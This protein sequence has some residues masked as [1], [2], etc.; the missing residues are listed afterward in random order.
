MLVS[1]VYDFI[2]LFGLQD[3]K[4]GSEKSEGGLEASVRSFSVNISWIQFGFKFV[5]FLVLWKVSFNYLLDVK[6]V[7]EAPKIAK[8]MKI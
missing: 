2:W 1:I 3:E 6:N 4:E 7:Y 8:I 5:V